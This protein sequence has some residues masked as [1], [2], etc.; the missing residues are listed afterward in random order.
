MRSLIYIN[1]WR[2]M[3]KSPNLSTGQQWILGLSLLLPLRD[4]NDKRKRKTVFSSKLHDPLDLTN[5]NDNTAT[6]PCED[7]ILLSSQIKRQPSG[8]CGALGQPFYLRGQ[9]YPV[10]AWEGRSISTLHFLKHN[11]CKIEKAIVNSCQSISRFLT[12]SKE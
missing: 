1:P 3:I 6:L 7:G 10:F 2:L 8:A 11:T 4:S 12:L 5:S 9:Q